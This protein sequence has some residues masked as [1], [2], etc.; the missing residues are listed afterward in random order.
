M[1]KH[2]TGERRRCVLARAEKDSP[3]QTQLR[4]ALGIQNK[5]KKV[6]KN[7]LMNKMN[8]NGYF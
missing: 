6:F 1:Q 4:S 2:V 3:T 5:I 7:L 8:E